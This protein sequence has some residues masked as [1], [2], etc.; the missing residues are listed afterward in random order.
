M[1]STTK[2]VEMKSS[3]SATL[4]S[5]IEKSIKAD[6]SET[7]SEVIKKSSRSTSVGRALRRMITGATNSE[8]D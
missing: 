4:D 2:S 8:S 3:Q 6:L 7:K 1:A 5:N